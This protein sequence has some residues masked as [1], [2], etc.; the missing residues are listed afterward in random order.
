MTQRCWCEFV[1]KVF[2]IIEAPLFSLLVILVMEHAGMS[3]SVL[4]SMPH[5][6]FFKA[7]ASVAAALGFMQAQKQVA[8]LDVKPSNVLRA[9]APNATYKLI[10]FDAAICIQAPEQPIERK[11]GNLCYAPAS[12]WLPGGA[13]IKKSR[14]P[15]NKPQTDLRK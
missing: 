15:Q 7:L 11:P 6:G 8:H 12:V 14:S 3:L 10:D 1:P 2:G 9:A 13:G 5:Q 4:D